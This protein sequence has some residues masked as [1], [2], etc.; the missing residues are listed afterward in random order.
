MA[1]GRTPQ[2]TLHD[3]A[4]HRPS[5]RYREDQ[6]GNTVFTLFIAISPYALSFT[7]LTFEGRLQQEIGGTDTTPPLRNIHNNPN[8]EIS[9]PATTPP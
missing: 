1:P 6:Q 8:A 7:V 9:S 3:A 4:N 5:A 2:Y